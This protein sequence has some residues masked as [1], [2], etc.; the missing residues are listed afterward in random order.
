M[1]VQ[2]SKLNTHLKI[3]NWIDENILWFKIA[4]ND[5][6]SL[7]IL[8]GQND[9]RGVDLRMRLTSKQTESRSGHCID[10]HVQYCM[11]T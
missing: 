1:T 2:L 7:K 8:K 4:V 9:L 10:M 6:K 11:F 3:A 5:V